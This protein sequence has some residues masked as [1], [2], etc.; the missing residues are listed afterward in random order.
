MVVY[1]RRSNGTLVLLDPAL[2]TGGTGATF[3]PSMGTNPLFSAFSVVITDDNRFVLA[4]NA[5]SSSVS[6]FKVLRDFSLRLVHVQP[7]DA[8]APSSI[9]IKGRLVYV[10][11]A[12]ADGEFDD[13]FFLEGVLEG[14]ALSASGRLIPI[15]WSRRELSFRP[16]TIQF[17]PDGRS[18]VVSDTFSSATA[19]ATGSFNEIVVFRVN[20]FGLLSLSPVSEAVSTELGNPEGRNLPTAFGF[21]IVKAGGVQYVVVPEVRNFPSAEGIMP[22]N[23]TSSVS[24][25]RLGSDGSLSPV[26]LDLLIGSSVTMGQNASCWIEFSADEEVFWTSNTF[27]ASVSAFSF[28][29]GISTLEEEVAATGPGPVDLWRSADG[30]FL[31]QLFSGAVGAYEVSEGGSGTG[32]TLIQ[33]P[34]NVPEFNPQGLV[35]F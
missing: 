21:E 15:P 7:V 28:E 26:Q 11:S 35:A 16:S 4:V 14:F 18:L 20:I 9:A 29:G 33:L 32:L 24:T 1:A 8:F 22:M 19:V 23:T 27:S 31:Y 30:K 6:V 13:P 5:G 25:W 34:M 12:D 3:P 10:A 2:K 17:S